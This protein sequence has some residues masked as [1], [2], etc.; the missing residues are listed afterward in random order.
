MNLYLDHCFQL[1][2]DVSLVTSKVRNMQVSCVARVA[3]NSVLAGDTEADQTAAFAALN[4]ITDQICPN[5]CSTNGICIEGECLCSSGMYTYI[6]KAI[7]CLKYPI[8]KFLYSYHV[9]FQLY[10]QE[11]CLSTSTFHIYA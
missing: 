10:H 7:V 3:A 2:D 4:F 9:L 11:L 8:G 6:F 1:I 5:Q